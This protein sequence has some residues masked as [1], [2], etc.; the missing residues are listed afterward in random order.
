MLGDAVSMCELSGV[1]RNQ[2]LQSPQQTIRASTK[3]FAPQM[4]VA[5][6]HHSWTGKQ[7]TQAEEH[8]IAHSTAV[9]ESLAKAV[10][11]LIAV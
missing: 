2:N 6:V 9:G 1:K 4:L 11:G 3:R 5:F 10:A 7:K 8:C